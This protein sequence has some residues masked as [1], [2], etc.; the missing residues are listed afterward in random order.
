MRNIV[1]LLL[2]T[3]VIILSGCKKEDL[4][5]EVPGCIEKEINTFKK[6]P[7]ACDE[8][9]KVV[10]Y[11]FQ[12]KQVYLFKPGNCGAD[13]PTNIYDSNCN[14]ICTLGGLAGNILCNAEIF[15]ENATNEILVWEN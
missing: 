7:F 9:A 10:R 12:N 13:M 2:A 11:D 6:S 5:V 1:K 4:K 3:L 14:L 15:F 8:E